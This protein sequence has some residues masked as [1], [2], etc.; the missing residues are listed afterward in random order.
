MSISD[1]INEWIR[2]LIIGLI[3]GN[4]TN[5]FGDVNDKVGT[6]AVEVGKSPS[7]WNNTIFSMI[8]NLSENVIVPIAGIIITFVL[9]YELI[10]MLI[11]RNTM[12]DID[13]WMFFKYFFK[14]W[15]AV[16]IVTHTF[17]ITMAVFDLAQ[18]VISNSA[19]SISGDT[20]I[21]IETA[22]ESMRLGMEE[23]SIPDLILMMLQTSI[24]QFAMK[25]M[26]VLITVILFG[27][28]IE[29]FIYC[30]ISPIPFATMT[31]REWGGM[32]TN[33]LKGL[34]AVAFQGFFIMVC[35]GVYAVLVN[36]M[37]LS[38]DP[39]MALLSI[40]AYTVLLC[41]SLFKTGSLSRSIFGSH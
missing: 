28:M 4:L 32:G 23:M 40:V 37:V 24:V 17:D 20:A 16:F 25:I 12:H 19:G 26:S 6:I 22:L 34:F 27:R 7:D 38:D 11:E 18:N 10:N 2:E 30:S 41:Y 1:R 31:N 33:Y 15:V 8:R 35:V 5:M 21:N 29:I 39:N 14:M 9:C 13:T 3:E 36:E